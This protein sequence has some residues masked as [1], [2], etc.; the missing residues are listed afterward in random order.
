MNILIIGSGAREHILTKAC[1]QSPTP[2]QLFC[3]GSS[4][5]PG[6][7]KLCAD[8]AV[9]NMFQVE[10]VLQQARQWTIQ[11]AIIGPEAPL[12]QGLADAFERQGILTVGPK[13]KSAQLETSKAFTRNLFS[14]YRIP[15]S[16]QYRLF[17]TLDDVK[18]FLHQLGEGNYVVKA[19]GLMGGKGVKVAGDH[20]HSID[21]AYVFCQQLHEEKIPFLIEEKL[22]GQEFSLLN[23]CDGERLIPMPLVQDHKRA[24]DGDMGPNTGGMGSYSAAD[25]RLP[26]LTD[27]DIKA[28]QHINEQTIRA[29]KQECNETYQGILYGSFIATTKGVYLIE[30]NARF[31]DP[32]IL[33]LLSIFDGDFV[34]LCTSLVNGSLYP[35]QV[36]FK[37]LATVCKYAVPLGYP[38]AVLDHTPI[39]ISAVQNQE[40]LYFAQ[41]KEH[42]GTLMSTSSRTLAVV[43]IADTIAKAEKIAEEE[44]SRVQGALFHRRDIGTA[45]LIEKRIQMMAALR[46]EALA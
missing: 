31:G 20:L 11:M 34:E 8:Y 22:I 35:E 18:P 42:H 5:N 39:S 33:N 44:I 10:A 7:K 15:G 29:L 25:H 17:H 28:A 30:Y 26:F 38:D 36:R 19:N 23:F 27:Q 46:E 37:H 9:M 13:K 1:A 24:F 43:G 14:N 4:L 2:C 16:P 41:V 40:Q 32:E 6:I 21:E 3:I 45:A 12:E